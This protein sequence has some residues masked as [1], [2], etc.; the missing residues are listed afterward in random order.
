[1]NSGNTT[2]V[3]SLFSYLTPKPHFLGTGSET[4]SCDLKQTR[5][6]LLTNRVTRATVVADANTGFSRSSSEF[7]KK[8]SLMANETASQKTKIVPTNRRLITRATAG[9]VRGRGKRLG[10]AGNR[11]RPGERDRSS[12]AHEMIRSSDELPAWTNNEGARIRAPERLVFTPRRRSCAYRL[13]LCRCR[14]RSLRCLCLRIFFRRFLISLPTKKLPLA[15]VRTAGAIGR[16]FADSS[17]AREKALSEQQSR[18]VR[19]PTDRSGSAGLGA[20]HPA[21]PVGC[22]RPSACCRATD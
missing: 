17:Q 19:F 21:A 6:L 10:P 16:D 20:S 15:P 8:I 13:C 1:M 7:I 9:R 4:G 2:L 11:V 5:Q 18:G 3:G 14:L 12:R 22:G